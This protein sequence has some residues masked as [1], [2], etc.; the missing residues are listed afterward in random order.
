[1]DH[2]T[3]HNRIVPAM[4]AFRKAS[5]A[6]HARHHVE[7]AEVVHSQGIQDQARR[8]QGNEHG[9][10][11]FHIQ[12]SCVPYHSGDGVHE[13]AEEEGWRTNAEEKGAVNG[14]SRRFQEY[15]L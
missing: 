1:M 8:V 2:N 14:A 6:I 11:H 3:P 9:N 10:A 13:T 4:L 7:N 15:S 12:E 5:M